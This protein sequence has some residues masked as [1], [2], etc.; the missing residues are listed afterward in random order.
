M[1]QLLIQI[2]NLLMRHPPEKVTFSLVSRI[3]KVPRPTLYYYFGK[4]AKTMLDEAA[5]FGMRALTQYYLFDQQKTYKTWNEFQRSRLAEAMELVKEFPWAPMV[6]FQYRAKAGEWT[7]TIRSVE[8]KYCEEMAKAW[9]KYHG[10]KPD[11]EA[12]RL[13]SYLKL[14]VLWGFALESELWL[15]PPD[16]KA[17]DLVINAL[18]ESST[19]LSGIKFDP[20]R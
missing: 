17:L 15:N 16:E 6:Y 20:R 12:I 13:A 5:R 14:G 4:S 9:E 11:L 10:K 1:D 8:D 2:L 7:E 19:I 18:T 3:T